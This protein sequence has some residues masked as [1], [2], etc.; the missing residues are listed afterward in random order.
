MN[1]ALYPA[2]VRS[3]PILLPMA[4]VPKIAISFA[5]FLSFQINYVAPSII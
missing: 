4:P 3:A 1:S 5:I 2:F